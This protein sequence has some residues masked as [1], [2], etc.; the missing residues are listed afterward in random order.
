[1]A[2]GKKISLA[3]QDVAVI[4]EVG[5]LYAFSVAPVANSIQLL[6]SECKQV[7]CAERMLHQRYSDTL[8]LHAA[9]HDVN[10]F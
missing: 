10:A 1:M 3:F 6:V 8:V 7:P 9:I 2:P 5:R 4:W